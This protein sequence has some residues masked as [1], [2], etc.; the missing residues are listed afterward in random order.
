MASFSAELRVAGHV[1]PVLHCSF[2]VHQATQERGRVS[3][4]V[5]H[6]PVHLTLAVPDGN[7]LLAWAADPHKRQA[8]S[9]VF[10]NAAGGAA[11][12]TLVLKAAYCIDYREEFVAGSARDGAYLLHLTLSDPNGWI[13]QAGGLGAAFVAPAAREHG[14]PMVAAAPLVAPPTG[15]IVSDCTESIRQNLQNQVKQNCKNGKQSCLITDNCPVLEETMETLNACIA[16]R[17]KINMKCFKGGDDGHKEQIEN[18]IK[19]LVR[20]QGYYFGK[21][22]K[23]PQPVP[24]LRRVPSTKPVTLPSVPKEVPLTIAGAGL[25]ILYLLSGALR[26]GPI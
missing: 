2:G 7:A 19:S 22:A 1:F 24:S 8:A 16:A 26:P 17:T 12:E 5:R 3:S 14:V 13:I 4:K 18:K 21:C 11:L 25:F 15:G 23:T 6:E 9:L 20:C 10:K